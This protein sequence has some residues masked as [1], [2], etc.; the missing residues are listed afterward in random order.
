MDSADPQFQV[1]REDFANAVAWVAR[2]LPSGSREPIMLNILLEVTE[3][4]LSVTAFNG[5]TSAQVDVPAEIVAEGTALVSGR[6]LAEI[7]KALPN[8]PVQV[9]VEDGKMTIRC[10]SATFTLPTAPV[11]GYPQIPPLPESSGTAELDTFAEAVGQVAVAAGKDDT[12]PMLTGVKVEISGDKLVLIATD[13]FRLAIR[14]CAWDPTDPQAEGNVLVPAKTLQ[15]VARSAGH[16][17]GIE[18]DLGSGA[19]LG[20]GRIL[21]IRAGA[22]RTTARLLDAEFPEVRRL[23]PKQHSALAAVEVAPLVAAIKR[24]ALVA[25]RGVQVRLSFSD[26]EVALSAGGDDSAAANETLPAE[27]TGEGEFTIAFNP[28]YLLDGLGSIATPKAV[29]GFTRPNSPAVIW[30]AQA[31]ELP[32]ADDDGSFAPLEANHVYLLMPV[33]LPG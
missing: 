12:L 15:D 14:E 10:G 21:G 27:F 5:D 29:L 25:D 2:S 23:L 8:K 11:E 13:R 19:Q 33:R 32:G 22:H 4:G 20:S 7:A 24:V 1:M 3:D 30:P 6:L 31:D 16:G 18:L 28:A 26:G 9:A 17:G